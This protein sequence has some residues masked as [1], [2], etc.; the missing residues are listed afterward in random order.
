MLNNVNDSCTLEI[1]YIYLNT[2]SKKLSLGENQEV[3]DVC[4]GLFFLI[5]DF[6]IGENFDEII[7]SLKEWG[8]KLHVLFKSTADVCLKINSV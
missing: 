2:L 3:V 5:N 7:Q 4:V 1:F 6:D 8:F